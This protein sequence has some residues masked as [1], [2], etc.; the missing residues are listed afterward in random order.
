MRTGPWGNQLVTEAEL[1]RRLETKSALE[2]G[3]TTRERSKKEIREWENEQAT[4]GLRNRWV[5][6]SRNYGLRRL[7]LRVRQ[8]LDRLVLRHPQAWDVAANG[9]ISQPVWLE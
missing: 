1:R 9:I 6:V 8:A 2:W 7:G 5:A 3:T 4:G